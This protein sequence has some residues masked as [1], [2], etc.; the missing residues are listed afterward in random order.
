MA[1]AKPDGSERRR[2]RWRSPSD[3]SRTVNLE[4]EQAQL[5]DFFLRLTG[6][7]SP[8]R[9]ERAVADLVRSE[10]EL[11]GLTVEEDETGQAIGGDAG[12]LYV[13]VKGFTDQAVVAFGAHLDTVQPTGELRPVLEDGVFRNSGGTILGADNKAAVAALVHS[14]QLLA[15]SGRP[16]PTFELCFTVAEEVGLQGARHLA[17]G[18]IEARHGVMF[19]STGPLGGIVTQAPSQ[20]T[21]HATFVGRAAH[22]GLEPESGL[23]AI[24]AAARGIALLELGRLDEGTTAN[25]GVIQGGV[26]TNIVPERCEVK[27][28]ARSLD[29]DKLVALVGDMVRALQAGATETGVDLETRLVPEYTAF[30]LSP[31]SQVVRLVTRAMESLGVAPELHTSGGG[32]DANVFNERGIPTVNLSCG[33]RQVHTS[34]ESLALADLLGLV[35]LVFAI[36]EQAGA[37]RPGPGGQKGV[38]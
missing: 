25:V 13:R 32:S 18:R 37:A 29:P 35:R 6:I 34:T 16:F 23:N 12:N 24:Q 28:E 30:S 2:V 21:I 27:A 1:R 26:A 8:S 11:A 20:H 9:S 7:A 31:R 4:P 14:A 19:D 17:P 38:V 36:L 3:G 10:L 22:A 15:R 5:A 33:M